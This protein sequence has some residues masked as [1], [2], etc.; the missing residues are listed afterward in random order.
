M[1]KTP[2]DTSR[3]FIGKG[4][5]AERY[6]VCLNTFNKWL[7]RLQHKLPLYIKNQRNFSPAQ[8][9]MLDYLLCHGEER[10]TGID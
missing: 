6:G 8:V 2:K 3:L 10:E 4:Q 1:E 9:K 5:L 7:K